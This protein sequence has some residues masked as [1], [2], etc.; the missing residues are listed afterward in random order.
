MLALLDPARYA[1]AYA[2]IHARLGRLLT[3]AT[4]DRLLAAVDLSECFQRLAE[5]PYQSTV[6]AARRSGGRKD[7]DVSRVLREGDPY[8]EIVDLADGLGADL[9]VMSRAGQRGQRRK[10]T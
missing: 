6:Q 10:I 3:S 4:W 8:R 1:A 9:S 7:L 2:K 5:T